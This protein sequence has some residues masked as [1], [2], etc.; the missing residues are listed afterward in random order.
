MTTQ[1]KPLGPEQKVQDSFEQKPNNKG[2]KD[3]II[4]YLGLALRV[5]LK[6]YY[7]GLGVKGL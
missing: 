6:G 1:S 2:P 5:P 3:P 7:R 4:R